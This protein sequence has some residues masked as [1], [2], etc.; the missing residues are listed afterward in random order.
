MRTIQNDLIGEQRFSVIPSLRVST[1]HIG[2]SLSGA[3]IRR[4]KKAHEN[5][6]LSSLDREKV[7]VKVK[8]D[9]KKRALFITL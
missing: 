4:T 7:G 8:K 1:L 9:D 3:P 2:K 5:Q 6:V